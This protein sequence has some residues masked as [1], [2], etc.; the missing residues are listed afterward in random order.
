MIKLNDIYEQLSQ[1]ELHH[2][3]AGTARDKDGC[4]PK[5]VLERLW[6]SVELGI[7][8]LHKRLLLREGQFVVELQTGQSSYL[9]DFKYAQSNAASGEPVKWID[10]GVVNFKD[11]LL[12]VERVYGDQENHAHRDWTMLPLN[13]V[14]NEDSL[15]TPNYKQLILPDVPAELDYENI[16]VIYRADHP[17]ISRQRAISTPVGVEIELSPAHIQPLCYFVAS[18]ILNTA[19]FDGEKHEGNNYMLKFEKAISD[20][21]AQNLRVAQTHNDSRFTAG[22]WA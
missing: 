4:W 6:P 1:G 3:Y 21:Q 13:D 5:D 11:D 19:G 15:H 17:K 22:G 18:R 16:K 8:E 10:D 20:L 12:K 2:V 7:T 14:D 9:L